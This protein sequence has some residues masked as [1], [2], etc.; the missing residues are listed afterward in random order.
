LIG[1]ERMPFYFYFSFSYFCYNPFKLYFVKNITFF[2]TSQKNNIL[3]KHPMKY[4][5]SW[6]S[7]VELIVAATILIILTTIWFFS[8]SQYLLDA[9]D[10]GRKSDLST[11]SSSMK[12]YKQKRWVF[13]IPWANYSLT[14]WTSVAIQWKL[15]STVT[16]STLE[17]LPLDPNLKLPY[18]YSITQN[19]SEYLLWASLENNGNPIA[20][21][22]G[23]YRSVARDRLPSILVAIDG[24]ASVDLT[25]ATNKDKFIFSNQ[26]HN[27]P[28][29]LETGLATSD[30]TTFTN[31]M[32]DGSTEFW[33]N[34]DFRSCI[35]IG[36][37]G[38]SIGTWTYQIV[39]TS[40]VITDIACTVSASWALQ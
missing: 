28:Y 32:A 36:E 11:I 15:D 14:L 33:Q 6:F 38:K 21:V 34:T 40:W 31:L 20:Y 8:Y 2:I 10:S 12:L 27:L 17:K 16:L 26:S 19:K 1:R 35:E 9:R 24:P 29:D 22:E 13:P 18:L 5:P 37:S 4:S 23:S 25:N 3:L 39:N 30:G 7:F